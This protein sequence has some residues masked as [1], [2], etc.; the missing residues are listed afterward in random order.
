MK[1]EQELVVWRAR[2]S[3][4]D[5]CSRRIEELTAELEQER[6]S[7]R[8]TLDLLPIYEAD[9]ATE[10]AAREQAEK[11]RDAYRE[12]L[13][14][15]TCKQA[16]CELAWQEVEASRQAT[17]A[18]LQQAERELERSQRRVHLEV[19]NNK[20]VN[21]RNVELQEQL[22][23]ELAARER[24]EKRAEYA[25]IS[26]KRL[27]SERDTALAQVKELEAAHAELIDMCKHGIDA[28]RAAETALATER[29]S[30]EQAEEKLAEWQEAFR[31]DSADKVLA[32]VQELIEQYNSKHA[33]W[34]QRGDELE[35]AETALASARRYLSSEI[36]TPDRETLLVLLTSHPAPVAARERFA[37][38]VAEIEKAYEGEE[39]P[40]VLTSHP[41]PAAAPERSTRDVVET[42]IDLA[43]SDKHS[44]WN[45][46]VARTAELPVT[47]MATSAY[48]VAAP[49]L[50]SAAGK[51]TQLWADLSSQELYGEALDELMQDDRQ[52]LEDA[53]QALRDAEAA[54]VAAPCAGCATP[55]ERKVLEVLG[56]VPNT[57]IDDWRRWPSG[58]LML[59]AKA[60]FA[61]RSAKGQSLDQRSVRGSRGSRPLAASESCAG[62]GLCSAA[63]PCWA[64]LDRCRAL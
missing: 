43:K 48:P 30:R 8:H 11:A 63:A 52:E 13:H 56:D 17:Q 22:A 26:C 7:H 33:A 38:K 31:F 23:T 3:T 6:A 45:D 18:M 57:L 16:D 61:R 40:G 21:H 49:S 10:R 37:A 58:W 25:A 5:I 54:P 12:E 62:P 44:R 41:A 50:L 28:H 4:P 47:V 34:V 20:G 24:A 42:A 1:D 27:Q 14:Q 64:C 19:E 29:A 46:L 59:L 36:G 53:M 39:F 9:L 32:R 51:V 2:F 35:A 55:E 60:E 15:R